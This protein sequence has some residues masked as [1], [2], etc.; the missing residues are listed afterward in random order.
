MLRLTKYSADVE[1]YYVYIVSKRRSPDTPIKSQPTDYYFPEAVLCEKSLTLKTLLQGKREGIDLDDAMIY[2]PEVTKSTKPATLKLLHYDKIIYWEDLLK[3]CA[4]NGDVDAIDILGWEETMS[5]AALGKW[6]SYI[7]ND[8]WTT[9]SDD[10]LEKE[11]A[12]VVAKFLKSQGGDYM[13]NL[14]AR[15]VIKPTDQK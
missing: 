15:K 7:V 8:D 5:W 1:Q 12:I 3:H 6:Y 13:S 11:R 10:A 9:L 4:Q 2:D 14:S